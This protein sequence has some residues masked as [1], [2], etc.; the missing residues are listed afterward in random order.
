MPEEQQEVHVGTFEIGEGAIDPQKRVDNGEITD[1][2]IDN[3]SREVT[4][5]EFQE[6][7][8]PNAIS[9]GCVDGRCICGGSQE[10]GPNAAGGTFSL[11]MADALTTNSYRH[12]GEKAPEHARRMYA[13]LIKRGHKIGGHGDEAASGENSGCGAQDKLDAVDKNQ[14][15][16]LNYIACRG[17]DVRQI[18]ESLG[19]EVNDSLH[20]HIVGKAHALRAENYATN[21]AEL[22]QAYVDSND[23]DDSIVPDVEGKHKEV[24]LLVNTQDSTTLN[25]DRVKELLGDDMQAFNL[26]LYGLENGAEAVSI[27]A[28]EAQEKFVAAL[29]YNVATA[30]VLAGPSLRM[31][32]R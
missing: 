29:Y 8:D 7:T 2:Q 20:K 22:R 17:D 21:G 9:C 3:F 31:M 19:V 13:E 15:S 6:P 30:G 24:V 5:D 27:D 28:E 25:R 14:P 1:T 23:G 26:D 11:V 4:R 12:E 16:I 10:F 32:V 18:I